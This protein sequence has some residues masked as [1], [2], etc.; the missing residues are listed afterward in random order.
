MNLKQ[1]PY[2][3]EIASTGNLSNAAS[4]LNISQQALS[5][6]LAQ[7][8]NSLGI[9]LFIHHK[10]RMYPT[11]AGKVYLATAQ[12]ILDIQANVKDSIR[13]ID[14][15]SKIDLDIGISPHRGTHFIAKVYPELIRKYPEVHLKTHDGYAQSLRNMLLSNTISLASTTCSTSSIPG[16][17]VLPIHN[18]EILLAVPAFHKKVKHSPMASFGELPFAELADFKD[19][20]FVMPEPGTPLYDII[21][22]QF[23]N[24]GFLPLVSFSS[25]NIQLSEAMIRSGVG[26]GMLPAYYMRPN[27]EIVYYRL[28]KPAHMTCCILAR[29]GY[30]FTEPE[31][32]LI[33]L[34]FQEYQKITCYNILWSNALEEIQKEFGHK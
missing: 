18:E 19:S 20:S 7:L 9:E 1:L 8:E 12:K 28:Y 22:P 21:Q 6:Y 34:L 25:A 3:L 26:I 17:Q 29:T 33:Y 5:K 2:I 13:L 11:D 30:H 10:K 27:H 14:S 24:A 4:N 15:P 32:Y 31:R 16:M 23:V